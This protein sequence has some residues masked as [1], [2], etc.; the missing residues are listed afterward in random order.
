MPI[1]SN[2]PVEGIKYATGTY[3]LNVDS[4]QQKTYTIP[5]NIGFV[6]DE[7]YVR[8]SSFYCGNAVGSAY[9]SNFWTRSDRTMKFSNEESSNYAGVNLSGITDKQFKITLYTYQ[10]GNISKGTVTVT[11]VALKF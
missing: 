11:W 1:L 7:L 6:P 9:G 4:S 5:S 3:S 8:L 2:L 10:S